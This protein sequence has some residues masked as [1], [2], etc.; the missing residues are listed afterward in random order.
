MGCFVWSVMPRMLRRF[1]VCQV[2]VHFILWGHGSHYWFPESS[3][4][5]VAAVSNGR[6]TGNEFLF[7]LFIAKVFK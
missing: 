3:W 6:G 1:F 2:C 7:P 5:L 4:S